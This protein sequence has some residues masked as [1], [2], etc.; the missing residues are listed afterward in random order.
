M[1][2][3]KFQFLCGGFILITPKAE[4]HLKAHPEVSD[5][6][7]EAIGHIE[8]PSTGFLST[9]VELGRVIGKTSRVDTALCDIDSKIFFAHRIGRDKPSRVLPSW[10]VGEDTTKIVVL[11]RPSNSGEYIL[12]SSWI[13]LLARK[14]PWDTMI[15]SQGEFQECLKFWRSNALIHDPCV[16]GPIFEST[17]RNVLG[18][19]L[20]QQG[21]WAGSSK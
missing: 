3:T 9:E 20:N 8:L 14:E 19:K 10:Y 6:L 18:E 2:G 7:P 1:V 15:A 13:G 21:T 5:I 16:M 4:D 11:A 17:W 12:V